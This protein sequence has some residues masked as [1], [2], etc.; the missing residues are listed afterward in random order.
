MAMQQ[1]VVTFDDNFYEELNDILKAIAH[2]TGSQLL[3]KTKI[4]Y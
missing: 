3:L 2:Y 4:I 1:V